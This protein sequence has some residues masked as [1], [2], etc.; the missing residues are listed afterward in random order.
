M[1]PYFSDVFNVSEDEVR[2]YGAFNV[3]LI[4]DLPLFID[5]FL[6]FESERKE[7]Q[8][9]HKQVI[10]YLRFLKEKSI[11]H[12]VS[13]VELKSWFRFPEVEQNWFGFSQSGNA[14]RG[15]GPKFARALN[16]NLENIFTNFGNERITD[17]SHLEKLCLIE[18]GV[19]K[20]SISDFTTNLI[21]EYLLEFTEKFAKQFLKETQ[22]EEF[23]VS[24]V[25]FDYTTEAWR[26]KRFKLPIYQNDYIL[27][28]PLDLLTKENT[29]IN[30]ENMVNEIHY[31]PE[32]IEN[33]VLGAQVNSYLKKILPDNPTKKD[34]KRAAEKAIRKF[35]ELIDY[36]IRLKEQNGNEALRNS[37]L[38]VR[39]SR[40]LYIRK[41][42]SL[43]NLLAENSDFYEFS[44]VTESETVQRI[45]FFKD[46]IENKGGH[47][48][49][50]V[51]GEPMSK[52]EDLHIMFRLTW[53]APISDISREVNDGRGPVD[54]KISKGALDK[55]LVEFKLGSN[56]KLKKNLLNQVDIYKKA[57]DA[58]VGYKVIV[59]FTEKELDRVLRIL[60]ELNLTS[61]EHIYLVDARRDNKPSGSV[62]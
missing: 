61:D 42:G 19:G 46:V 11:N 54:F 37:A 58:K 6:L 32:A 21:K 2:E 51:G 40:A 56:T 24:K 43:I 53:F 60:E 34:N 57:S 44:G 26:P 50:Y 49:F 18:K 23:A 38:K 27:L 20:D 47:K 9:L 30:R 8:L 3:C 35:P 33:D 5:P 55:T 12:N 1:R 45:E 10:R 52:E 15:L 4:T 59:Y 25:Y 13:P 31:V 28:T 16:N 36:Y 41:F 14:G 62:A 29:W 48:I 7:Y 17:S 22:V 39:E